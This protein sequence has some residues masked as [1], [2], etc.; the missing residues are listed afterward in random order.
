MLTLYFQGLAV[1]VVAYTYA[2][3][4]TEGGMIL[5][6]WFNFLDRKFGTASGN[7]RQGKPPVALWLFKPLIGCFKCVAGQMALW[8]YLIAYFNNYNL[9]EHIFIICLSIYL[10]I[11]L[12][13]IKTHGTNA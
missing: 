9:F 11:I 5:N 7:P 10:S 13:K 12:H 8:F 3:I 2:A 4:L 6:F 1:A